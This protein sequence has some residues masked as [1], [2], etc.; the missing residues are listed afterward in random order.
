MFV[1]DRCGLCCMKVG[2]SPIY[3]KLDRGDGVC[4][5]FD[6]ASRLCTIYESRPVLCNV[7][8][9]YHEFFSH[10]IS[11]EEYYNLNYESCKKLKIDAMRGT[12]YVFNDVK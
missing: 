5:Y 1:C 2:Q 10:K 4:Q 12:D 11:I 6:D 3:A 9:V 8:E 7:D